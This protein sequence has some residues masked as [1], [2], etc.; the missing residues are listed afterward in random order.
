[1]SLDH[2]IGWTIPVRVLKGF[3]IDLFLANQIK[4]RKIHGLFVDGIWP[5]N[6]WVNWPPYFKTRIIATL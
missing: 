4:K 2:K 3:E 6:L 5:N 1:M